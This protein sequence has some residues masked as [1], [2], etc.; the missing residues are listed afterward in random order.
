MLGRGLRRLREVVADDAG[1][2]TVEAAYALAAIVGVVVMGVGAVVGATT[3]IR[4][5]DAAREAARLG[6]VGDADAQRT[7]Q[8]V[9]GDDAS[10][11]VRQNE[12]Q[13]IVEV[14]APVPLFR[15]IEVSARAVAAKEP[16]GDGG[17]AGVPVVANEAEDGPG[18]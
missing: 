5:T 16:E 18:P 12:S 2:V 9:V 11:T 14:R 4:C 13:V 3:Q 7:A 8:A 6:A 1:M 10:I 17:D 15:M